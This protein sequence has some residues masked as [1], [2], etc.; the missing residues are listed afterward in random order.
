MVGVREQEVGEVDIT[1]GDVD[2]MKGVDE[3]LDEPLGIIVVQRANDGVKAAC[4]SVKSSLETLGVV[5]FCSGVVLGAGAT[6]AAGGSA[7][8]SAGTV[9]W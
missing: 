4:A 1:A 5:I 7:V 9:R 6:G 3:S 2:R 8:E